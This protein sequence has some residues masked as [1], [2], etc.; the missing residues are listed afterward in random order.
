MV[1][2]MSF[3]TIIKLLTFTNVF[4]TVSNVAKEFC[5]AKTC[6]VTFKIYTQ[7]NLLLPPLKMA[8]KHIYFWL[9]E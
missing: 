6:P 4:H 3:L 9:S 8:M 1:S 2:Q 7:H 5:F